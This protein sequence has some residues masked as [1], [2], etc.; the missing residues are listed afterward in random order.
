MSWYLISEAQLKALANAVR[1]KAGLTE[2]LRPSEMVDA[3]SNIVVNGD[4]DGVIQ[5]SA[6]YVHSDTATSVGPNA[7]NGYTELEHIDLPLARVIGNDAFTGCTSLS[8][9]NLPSLAVLGARVFNYCSGLT[10]LDLTNASL[11][12]I[13]ANTFSF[14]GLREL[15]LPSS[16][17]CNVAPNAFTNCPL[18]SGGNGGTIYLPSRYRRAYES[19]ANW[20]SVIGSENNTIIS[21]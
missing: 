3:V 17:F 7:F 8:V 9:V 2:K 18:A 11:T 12:S 5:R 21:Y 10:S 13:P 20:A 15:R 4:L 16:V 14:S 6:S 19:N 1:A